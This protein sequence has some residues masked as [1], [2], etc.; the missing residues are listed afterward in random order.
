MDAD[1]WRALGA[2]MLAFLL[3]AE[4]PGCQRG[5]TL[6]CEA[7]RMQLRPQ[8]VGTR[9]PGGIPVRAALMYEGVPAWCIRRVKEDGMTLLA[10][11]LGLALRGLLAEQHPRLL[12]PVPTGRASFRRRG[13][14]VP[15]LLIRR[16]GAE[17][18]R[19]LR[20]VRTV[21]DQRG[22]GRA[23]RTRNVDGS[24]RALRGDGAR[25]VVIVDDVVT[26]GATVDEAA[27]ALSAAGYRV[28]GA[29]ALAATPRRSE[30]R[31]D[32]AEL[33]GDNRGRGD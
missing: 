3:A 26:T 12:V 22:L 14:R 19:L 25:E 27:R 13:Y 1:A 10:R 8:P 9:T 15:E 2:E 23:Q 30:T 21:G 24:M 11:P 20:T 4:C 16:A 7:C 31:R 29:V 28:V 17:P 33:D 18:H 6:L 5:G 32:T